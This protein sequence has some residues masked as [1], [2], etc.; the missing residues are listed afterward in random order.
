MQI[1]EYPDNIEIIQQNSNQLLTIF[2]LNETKK[3]IKEVCIVIT[4]CC[5]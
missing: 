2:F 1:N 3:T 5:K 4:V